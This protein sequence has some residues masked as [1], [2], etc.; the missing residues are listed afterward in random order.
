[1]SKT[2]KHDVAGSP[3]T[4]VTREGHARG[5]E[6]MK[7]WQ[8]ALQENVYTRN[9]DFQHSVRF[10]F[11][12]DA[13]RLHPELVAFGEQ[14]ARELEPLVAENDF[15][16]NHP[17]LEPYTGVGERCDAVVHHPAYVQAGNIIYG[18]R[19]MERI[20]RPGGMLESLAFF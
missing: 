8:S 15:R 17:R 16:F 9:P 3:L 5:R 18:S 10:Y 7:A 20:A 2:S 11:D 12:T 1:M 4:A 6:A 14:V 19:M 13:E